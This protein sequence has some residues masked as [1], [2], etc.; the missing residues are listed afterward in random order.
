MHC[1][2]HLHRYPLA[3]TP[4]LFAKIKLLWNCNLSCKFCE[5]PPVKQMMPLETVT[6]ILHELCKQG[7]RKIHFS[8]GEVLLHP[9]IFTILKQAVSLGLQVNLT[10]NGTLL[11]KE[12]ARA[13]CHLKI[14]SI[15]GTVIIGDFEIC[16]TPMN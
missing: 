6:A 3:D 1:L 2:T 12:T 13:L 7:L 14:H 15:L 10:T 5:R 16:L 4:L 8:G 11:T 9:Q